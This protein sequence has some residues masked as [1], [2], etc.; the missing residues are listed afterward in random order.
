MES[1]SCNMYLNISKTRNS[2]MG[3]AMIMIVIFHTSIKYPY[4]LD[5]MKNFGDF[6]VNIFFLVS[7]FSMYFAWKKT[8]NVKAFYVKRFSRILITI[9]QQQLYGVAFL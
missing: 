8:P 2:L 5:L 3:I 4:V 1:E 7:G 9:G 6:G